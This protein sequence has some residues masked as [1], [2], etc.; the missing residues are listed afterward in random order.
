MPDRPEENPLFLSNNTL[1]EE[2]RRE[3]NPFTSAGQEGWASA[4]EPE[5][6][7]VVVVLESVLEWA[8]VEWALVF[9]E[10]ERC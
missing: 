10:S 2:I 1:G 3:G 4:R 8:P 5:S 9:E 7:R 6:V